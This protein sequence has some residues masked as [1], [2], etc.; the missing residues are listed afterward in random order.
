MSVIG[1]SGA[2]VICIAADVAV[3]DEV[4]AAARTAV[5]RFGRIDTWVNNAGVSIYGRLDQVSEADRRLLRPAA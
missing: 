4:M 5:E 3:R 2:D 1:S